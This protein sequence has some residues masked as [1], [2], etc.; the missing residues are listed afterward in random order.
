M[1]LSYFARLALLLSASFFLLHLL[2][3]AL[4]ASLA[5][6]ALRRAVRMRPDRAARFLLALRLLPAAFSALAVLALCM[7]GYLKFEP[8]IAS[9]EVG[10]LCV[11]AAVLGMLFGAVAFYKSFSAIARTALY[12]RRVGG[13]QTRIDGESV[14]I[15]QPDNGIALAGVF[16]PRILISEKAVRELTADELTVAV[17]HEQA[18]RESRDNWKRL[19]LLLSPSIF[20]GLRDLEQAWNRSA[21]WAADDRAAA[22]EAERSVSLASALVRVARLQSGATMPPLVTSLIESDEDLTFRVN[23]LLHATPT[24]DRQSRVGQLALFGSVAAVALIAINPAAL[25][26]VHRLLEVLLD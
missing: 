14:W 13:V 4:A 9:E 23:R 15:V 26:V 2:L 17:R 7:P 12:M 5:K 18:H 21:E 16:S 24:A 6:S 3:S 22:G 25:R 19:L 20:P 1:T 10:A 11:A 8:R